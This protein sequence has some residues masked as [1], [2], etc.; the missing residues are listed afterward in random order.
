MG[1]I[2]DKKWELLSSEYLFRE[3]WL[4]AR[5]DH[6]RLPSG[7]EMP[8]YYVLEYPDWV[9]VLALTKDGRFLLERQYRHAR[10]LTAFEIPAG[11]VEEGEDPL[12]AA[13][14]ELFEETGYTGGEWSFF[15]QLC[16]NAGAM[17]NTSTTFL[18]RGVEQTSTQ[19]LEQTEDIDI[20]LFSEEEVFEMLQ[21]GEFH[22]AMMVAPLW[23]YFAEQKG[24]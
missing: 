13:Q 2:D 14:R 5:R 22:Q 4:T 16:P 18:A 20:C 3:P 6:V 23:K 24:K 10:R 15:L 1:T 12:K 9:N 17:S 21:R 7:V 8:N 11:C 19:H